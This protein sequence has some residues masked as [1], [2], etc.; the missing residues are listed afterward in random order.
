MKYLADKESRIIWCKLGYGLPAYKSLWEHK[1][2]WIDTTTAPEHFNIFYGLAQG[3]LFP[4]ISR[5]P[6]VT[7]K[8]KNMFD[9]YVWEQIR[10]GVPAKE[11][12]EANLDN[13]LQY[14]AE[15]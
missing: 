2:L 4:E 3:A 15:M 8:A 5:S 9:K 1:E 12:L 13:L 6:I 11:A 10:R 14:N 7:T